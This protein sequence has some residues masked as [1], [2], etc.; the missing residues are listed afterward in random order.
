M[1]ARPL[2]DRGMYKEAISQ[3]DR[4][5]SIVHDFRPALNLRG[6]A[7]AMLGQYN[8]AEADFLKLISLTPFNSQG[9][10]NIGF[11][12]LLQGEKD[13]ATIY[14]TKALALAPQDKKIKVALERLR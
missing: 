14:L 3:V 1:R 4:C 10:R 2:F 7:Y 9:Y 11:L 8:M 12:Y 13:K 5:L 6:S